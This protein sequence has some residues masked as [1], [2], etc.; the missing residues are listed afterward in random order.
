[1]AKLLSL[2]G[3]A[4]AKAP[5][6]HCSD[7]LN[8]NKCTQSISDT[9]AKD[10]QSNPL[11][12]SSQNPKKKKKTATL[13]EVEVFDDKYSKGLSK[14]VMIAIDNSDNSCNEPAD[15][16]NIDDAIEEVDEVTK[17]ESD[18]EENEIATDND[19]DWVSKSLIFQLKSLLTGNRM[20]TGLKRNIG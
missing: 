8:T 19:S 2:K 10:G 12:T 18:D 16:D 5:P 11:V 6:S 9:S 13:T 4:K 1:M 3:K 15:V 14:K 17:I 20:M 7:Q